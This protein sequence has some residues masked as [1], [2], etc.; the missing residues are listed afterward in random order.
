MIPTFYNTF[1]NY[2]QS[3]EERDDAPSF[4]GFIR[5]HFVFIKSSKIHEG[6]SEFDD[7]FILFKK[8]AKH[9]GIQVTKGKS[10][11]AWGELIQ[12]APPR[13][14]KRS[15]LVA[16]IKERLEELKPNLANE[17]D[18]AEEDKTAMKKFNRQRRQAIE[19]LMDSNS[20]DLSADLNKL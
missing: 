12:V 16:N 13:S 19:E 11:K 7:W 17:E 15:Y 1:K 2:F 3:C 8:S 20:R 18:G 14:S 4:E 9:Y 5:R 6:S 10:A